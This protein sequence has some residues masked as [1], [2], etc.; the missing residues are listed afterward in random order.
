MIMTNWANLTL[1]L[2][3]VVINLKGRANLASRVILGTM[4]T[5][6]GRVDLEIRAKLKK[7]RELGLAAMGLYYVQPIF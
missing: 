4:V 1:A 7:T 5:T 3:Q 2:I 6:K